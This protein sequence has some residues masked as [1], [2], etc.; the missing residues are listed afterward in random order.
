MKNRQ[1]HFVNQDIRAKKVVLICGEENK[2]IVDIK[3]ALSIAW[4]SGLDLVQLN[5]NDNPTCKIMDYGKFRYEQSKK[6]KKQKAIPQK[7]IRLGLFMDQKDLDM[8]IKKIS[9]LLA[10]G[11]NVKTTIKLKGRQLSHIDEARQKT[12]LVCQKLEDI[13]THGKIDSFA[14]EKNAVVS[15]NFTPIKKG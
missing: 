12:E 3:D 13:A 6:G 11:C 4:S 9:Q 15:V 5:S 14:N 7:E 10:K 2:G 1:Q 8:K